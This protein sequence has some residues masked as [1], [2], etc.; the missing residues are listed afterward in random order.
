MTVHVDEMTTSVETQPEAQ[1]SGAP[2]SG[3]PTP[4][5][6]ERRARAAERAN[7]IAWRTH[8]EG[9]DD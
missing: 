2:A 8:A 9:Y 3:E 7:Q 5:E 6:L 1:P 4:A